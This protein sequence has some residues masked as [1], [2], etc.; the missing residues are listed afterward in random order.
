MSTRRREII[1]L[2]LLLLAVLSAVWV[3][4]RFLERRFAMQ[5]S[6]APE[7]VFMSVRTQTKILATEDIQL[8]N[9]DNAAELSQTV[10]RSHVVTRTLD[11][12]PNIPLDANGWADIPGVG[13]V[14]VGAAVAG[15]YYGSQYTFKRAVTLTA[16]GG[17]NMV[18]FIRQYEIWQ[19]GEMLIEGG[20]VIPYRFLKD[21]GI[22]VVASTELGCTDLGTPLP[23]QTAHE[24]RTSAPEPAIAFLEVTT[25]VDADGNNIQVANLSI[26]SL[27][28]GR[29]EMTAPPQMNMG[30]SATVHVTIIPPDTFSDLPIVIVSTVA[31]LSTGQP[32]PIATVQV[33][34]EL[35]IY[36][37]MRAE[38]MGAGFDIIADDQPEKP[39]V[40]GMAAVWSWTITAL[41]SG[42][43]TL[44]LT[45]S[46]PVKIAD[47]SDAIQRAS[48]LK[49]IDHRIEVL[50]IPTPVPTAT[51]PFIQRVVDN[52]AGN[53]VT[54]L[55]VLCVF[56]PAIIAAI[57]G[58]KRYRQE[59]RKPPT[60][61]GSSKKGAKRPR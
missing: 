20:G 47:G 52:V 18:H 37:V 60:K 22:E 31:P 35:Q 56:I 16:A 24:T 23:T 51:P 34:D 58:V 11:L 28:L 38:M 1:H 42:T 40:S 46:I 57:I 8:E 9:C 19:T 39:I 33:V 26:E 10:E 49:S 30:E 44:S 25:E 21:F 54:F 36:P 43:H 4:Y 3:G 41:R 12:G 50:E 32:T 14:N 15:Y 13:P 55:G 27:G 61:P 59:Q 17:T 7:V 2:A 5:A 48:T 45:I 29:V 53:F 6:P